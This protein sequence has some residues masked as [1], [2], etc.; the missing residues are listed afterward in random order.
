M[1]KFVDRKK[2]FGFWLSC[3]RVVL[4]FETKSKP[5]ACLEENV[6]KE[7]D[8]TIPKGDTWNTVK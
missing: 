1:V 5:A 2:E 8:R 6:E 7:F 3:G 4:D